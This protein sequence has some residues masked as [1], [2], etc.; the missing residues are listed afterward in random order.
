MTYDPILTVAVDIV[1]TVRF[2]TV[3]GTANDH[4]SDE[5]NVT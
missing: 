5:F 4:T 3:Y 1:A 2:S